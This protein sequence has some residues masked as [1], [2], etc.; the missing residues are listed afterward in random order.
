MGEFSRISSDE[1]G[2]NW[3]NVLRFRV[4]LQASQPLPR[5]L[6]I[7]VDFQPQPIWV[8]FSFERLPDFCYFC[9][10][11]DH[12]DT[13]CPERRDLEGK[14]KLF[15]SWMRAPLFISRFDEDSSFRGSGR[16]SFGG[17]A[18]KRETFRG[19]GRGREG[20]SGRWRSDSL[21]QNGGSSRSAS[22][23]SASSSRLS[24][25]E[26]RENSENNRQICRQFQ[27][28][29][30]T[31]D[32]VSNQRRTN[33][34]GKEKFK[35]RSETLEESPSNDIKVG[36]DFRDSLFKNPIF[37]A[38]GKGKAVSDYIGEEKRGSKAVKKLIFSP[39][40]GIEVSIFWDSCGP[41]I[42]PKS[43]KEVGDCMDLIED[44][45]SMGCK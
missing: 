9:G 22:V 28:L 13:D 39:L 43:M 7:M 45:S 27:A 3:R 15:G 12:L 24:G 16:R 19:R 8:T 17:R 25:G 34:Q 41:I 33:G 14:P 18:S 32:G 20:R 40:P 37:L 30:S 38:K 21:N 6:L 36:I 23:S 10:R 5:G 31:E 1:F 26:G 44:R 29:G 35:N 42:G 2:Y 11:V 4:K